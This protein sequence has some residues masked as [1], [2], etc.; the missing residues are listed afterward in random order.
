MLS[1]KTHNPCSRLLLVPSDVSRAMGRIFVPFLLLSSS[2]PRVHGGSQ[3]RA[4]ILV[5]NYSTQ[6][7]GR[8]TSS[9]L[10]QM[11]PSTHSIDGSTWAFFDFHLSDITS[12]SSSKSTRLAS[13]MATLPPFLS[14]IILFFKGFV[15][16]L[17]PFCFA[18]FFLKAVNNLFTGPSLELIGLG[19]LNTSSSR[20]PMVGIDPSGKIEG[21]EILYNGSN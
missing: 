7:G 5:A 12:S 18:F 1:S 3:H 15:A 17:S 13:S 16:K 14:T 19:L 9:S 4:S 11:F 20:P 10:H 21:T 6:N 2:Y 8:T